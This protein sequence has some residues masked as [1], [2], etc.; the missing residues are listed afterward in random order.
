MFFVIVSSESDDNLHP[1]DSSIDH[2]CESSIDHVGE[3]NSDQLTDSGSYSDS[4]E[5]EVFFENSETDDFS[6][7]SEGGNSGNSYRDYMVSFFYFN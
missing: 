5:N 3:G 2:V 7:N 4:Y 1:V 6:D